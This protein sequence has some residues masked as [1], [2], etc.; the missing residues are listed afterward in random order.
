M[1][2]SIVQRELIDA[3]KLSPLMYNVPKWSDTL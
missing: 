1:K 2:W 3:F